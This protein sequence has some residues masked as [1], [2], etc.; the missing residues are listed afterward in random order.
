MMERVDRGLQGKAIILGSI[1]LLGF[2][3][4]GGRL[5]QM[6]V[7]VWEEYMAQSEENRIRPEKVA[8][9]RGK[10]YDRNG[11]VLADSRP[12]FSVSVVPYQ[13]RQDP[14]V[15]DRLG[16]LI[17]VS[18]DLLRERVRKGFSRPY[19]PRPVVR[20]VDI[21][22]VSIVEER[23]YELSGV[24]IESEPVRRYPGGTLAAHLLGYLGEVSETELSQSRAV[25]SG[26]SAGT[27]V[28]RTGIERFYDSR[29]RGKDGVRYVQEDVR[30][31]P[32]G[33]IRDAEPV[34][35]EDLS[36]TLDSE[37]QALAESLIVGFEAGAVVALDPVEGDVLV[38]ASSPTYDPNL[39][40]VS[41]SPAVWDSLVQ[42][43][44]HPMLNRS[45]QSALPPGSTFKPITA[46]VGLID[47]LVRPET[48]L[49]PC[50][51]SYKFGRRT[52][53]CW[54]ESGHGTLVLKDAMAQSCDVYFYQIGAKMNLD[55]FHDIAA[56][57]ELGEMTGID[58]P[59]EKPGL[60]PSKRYMNERH[61]RSG[62]GPGFQL[63][64]SIGQGEILTTPLQIARF[65]GALATGEL[66]RPRILRHALAPDGTIL[67]G[68]SRVSREVD[69]PQ[70]VMRELRRGITAVIHGERGTGGIARVPGIT[71]AGKT[72]TAENPHGLEHAWFVVYA[73]TE[74]PE[75]VIAVFLERA[76]HGG[77]FA[78]PIA[79]EMLR[80]YFARRGV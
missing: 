8:A 40:A 33:T 35:G 56:S 29:L 24:L 20:D 5:F 15:L 27:R 21:E 43:Q 26:F 63:N 73:P 36:L 2:M 28:G 52:F 12:S 62:W 67:P 11:A 51:G 4:L 39:F 70:D 3:V 23:G 68:P 65:Y 77:E 30:G 32:L 44:F 46:A 75:I 19:E 49:L 53:G 59:N 61:G 22:T 64:H 6:Q 14:A 34:P 16:A 79:G 1:L 31:R 41:I 54:K 13:V 78:A 18:P 60:I 45:V 42:H 25:G 72:G 69:I 74:K 58:L 66:V 57:F 37:L 48:T 76:G 55:H 17:N 71:A 50:L 47:R 38:L 80:R 10:L 9:L 7:L